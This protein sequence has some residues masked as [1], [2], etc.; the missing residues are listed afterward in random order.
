MGFCFGVGRWQ[1]KELIIN[2]RNVTGRAGSIVF[3]LQ[4][5]K[6]SLCHRSILDRPFFPNFLSCQTH[7]RSY[8]PS[9]TQKALKFLLS[10]QKLTFLGNYLWQESG[11]AASYAYICTLP[12]HVNM[13]YVNTDL[14]AFSI[15]NWST[16]PSHPFLVSI[17][18]C[19]E[20]ECTIC[21][22]RFMG[23]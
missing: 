1:M 3:S 8:H 11:K 20:F 23:M 15:S 21:V 4:C 5:S 12:F 14:A 22:T 17:M 18:S 19:A 10:S 2:G 9:V 13:L 7:H 6:A 16:D